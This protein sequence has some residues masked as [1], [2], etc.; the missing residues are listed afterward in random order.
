[1]CVC[2]FCVAYAM[3]VRG[4]GLWL[5]LAAAVAGLDWVGWGDGFSW[6]GLFLVGMIGLAGVD[7]GVWFCPGKL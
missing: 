5:V 2:M 1:M 6:G 3:C 7:G 4:G